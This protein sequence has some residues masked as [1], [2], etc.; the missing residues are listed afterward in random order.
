MQFNL[1]LGIFLSLLV[2]ACGKID[3]A[4]SPPKTS[5]TSSPQNR[6]QPPAS[7]QAASGDSFQN[8]DNDMPGPTQKLRRQYQQFRNQ[9]YGPH[10]IDQ[11]DEYFAPTLA[12]QK[13]EI[14]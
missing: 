9:H 6:I 14:G 2:S 13:D 3:S 8:G 11:I 7:H 12:T 5:F 1:M 10:R 4:I